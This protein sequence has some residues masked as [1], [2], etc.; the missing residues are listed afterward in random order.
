[1][2]VKSL[3]KLLAP[4]FFLTFL[5]VC[6]TPRPLQNDTFYLIKLG[7]RLW[8]FGFDAKDHYTY[9]FDLY[10]SYP[11]FLFSLLC[12]GFYAAF[13]FIGEYFLSILLFLTLSF[14]LFY[15]LKSSLSSSKVPFVKTYLPILLTSLVSV[16]LPVFITARAQVLTY[17]VFLWELFLLEKLLKNSS[18]KALLKNSL[19][20]ALC[21]WL[22]A[23]CHATIWPFFF[24]LFLPLLAELF[25]WK[26]F[27]SSSVREN[28]S[29]LTSLRDK[30]FFSS[31][32]KSL[33]GE[34]KKFLLLSGVL[35]FLAGLL[36]P[37]RICYTAIFKI[38]AGSSQSYI[39]EH[40][41]LV[42][43]S[44]P[45]AVLFLGLFLVVYLFLKSRLRLRDL[46]LFFGLTL[47]TLSS[48]RN[49][50]LLLILGVLPLGNLL[51]S[52]AEGINPKFFEAVEKFTPKKLIVFTVSILL[53]LDFLKGLDLPLLAPEVAPAE[54]VTFLK[55]HYSENLSGL[56]LNETR[57]AS[58]DSPL[59]LYNEYNIGALLL[60][61]DIPVAI[62][63]RANIY[64]KPFS[65][66]LETDFFDDYE[67]L[68]NGSSE[69]F[70]LIEK[71]NFSTFLLYND[72]AL[73]N[74]LSR[75]PDY[76]KIYSDDIFSIFERTEK[77]EKIES[78]S[79]Q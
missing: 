62:D 69:A 26:A 33:P 65:N 35:S 75:D 7:D 14:S 42:L 3:I 28:R 39:S 23:I 31:E 10:Y 73:G 11:H 13:G 55:D 74:V 60:F 16:L 21:S 48:V 1:M 70:D 72:S 5:C 41:P 45:E 67:I 58:L 17:S 44:Y 32:I 12:F 40:A 51:A 61:E 54:A 78:S 27:K 57:A 4:Y 66:N 19:L 68:K 9:L 79:Q 77:P 22:V 56:D 6:L 18:R 34:N 37:S 8:N 38:M 25:F 15:I 29:A 24:V 64:T 59:R 30:F 50:A 71:Y 63:S 2:K 20:L 36:T 43:K 76:E 49:L 46:F 52:T 53:L 47:M